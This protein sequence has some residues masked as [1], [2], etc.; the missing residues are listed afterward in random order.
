MARPRSLVAAGLGLLTLLSTAASAQVANLIRQSV[1]V[2]VESG[3]LVNETDQVQ[4]LFQQIVTVDDAASMQVRF[5]RTTLPDGARIRLT[6]L[7]DGHVQH[8]NRET[9]RQWQGGSAWFNGTM[10]LVELVADPGTAPT[11]LTISEARYLEQLGDNR[12]ICGSTDDRVPSDDPRAGRVFPIGCSGW[13]ID[14]PNRTCLTAGHCSD[15]DGDVEIMQFN[16]PLSDANGNWQQPG[17]EDQYAVDPESL[18]FNYSTIGDDWA[19]FGCFP[20]T[21]TGLTPYQAQ[22]DSY[23][24]AD[25]A[26][27][28]DGQ[29]ITIIGYGTTSSPIDPTWNQAQKTHTGPY[30]VQDGTSIGYVVDTTGGNSGSA[31]LDESTGL[32]IGIHTN[33]GCSSG[34]NWGCG[35]HNAGLQDALANP[36]GVCIPQILEFSLPDGRPESMLPGMT[37]D[38]DFTVSAGDEEPVAGSIALVVIIDGTEVEPAVTSLGGDLYR[39]TI[40]ALECEQ[41]VSFY[42]RAEGNAGGMAYLPFGGADDAYPIAVGT[43][44]DTVV[45]S[46]EF[47]SGLPTGWSASGLWHAVDGACA[48]A[49][50]CGESTSFY[51]GQDGSCTYDTG[52]TATGSLSTPAM[53]L[54]G[55]YGALT[56]TYCSTL[57]TEDYSGY[58]VARVLA[59]GVVVDEVDESSSWQERTVSISGITGDTLTITWEFNSVDDLYNGFTGWHIDNPT[60]IATEANCDPAEPCPADASGNGAVDTDDI[61]LVIAHWG[62]SGG[63]A[64]INNDG[65]VNTA[66]ILLVLKFWGPC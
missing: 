42:L 1:P 50:D 23:I 44:D 26:P 10:V 39:A 61:L 5:G 15:S 22:G 30:A 14:D 3:S 21:E 7:T 54:D 64:D 46:E 58:D 31:V 55:I 33:G 49:N 40:P 12:S 65:T 28:V 8:H 45:M 38:L 56:L 63:A 52:G 34:N 13:I 41:D 32:A 6:S 47:S 19:Y 62:E 43:L 17:P 11:H 18:Q 20:N 24:L 27:P 53:S 35:I 36:K 9:L 59:N 60:L 29:N 16:V 25:V 2:R 4:V 48:P 51:F 37:H 66:D 57:Q